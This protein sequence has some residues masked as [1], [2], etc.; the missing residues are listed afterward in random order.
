M[1]S[2]PVSEVSCAICNNPVGLSADL[3]A[4]ENGRAVHTE[5]Y[6]KRISTTVARLKALKIAMAG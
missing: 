5:C 1:G 3:A 6:F 4:D 2:R